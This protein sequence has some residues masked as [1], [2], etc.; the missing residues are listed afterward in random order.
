MADEDSSPTS[1]M[2]WI[3]QRRG[4]MSI[5]QK[6]PTATPWASSKGAPRNAI[7][8]PSAGST[9][10][11]HGAG[12]RS[13]EAHGSRES[14]ARI[15]ATAG[16]PASPAGP[17]GSP[18]RSVAGGEGHDR[19]RCAQGLGRPAGQAIEGGRGMDV[20]VRR[21][22]LVARVGAGVP[23]RGLHLRF[24]GQSA[25]DLERMSDQS[26][27]WTDVLGRASTTLDV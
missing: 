11:A 26:A 6:L 22:L 9:V 4:R 17:C 18:R 10:R 5:T 3:V 8:I 1:S 2:S 20:E 12:L 14:A 23:T 19:D 24:I 16:W 25:R 15:C 13:H 7:P 21:W 27:C